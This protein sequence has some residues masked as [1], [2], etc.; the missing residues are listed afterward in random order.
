MIALVVMA[1]AIG[2]GS[3]DESSCEQVICPAGERCDDGECVSTDNGGCEPSCGDGEI[4]RDDRCLS[5]GGGCDH[6][7]QSCDGSEHLQW[8]EDFICLD[9][10]TGMGS[11]AVCSQDCRTQ[12][13]PEGSE[14]FLVAPGVGTQCA[15][16][17]ECGDQEICEQG[18][19][20]VASCRPSDCS[21][22]DG[23]YADCGPGER[24]DRIG[25]TADYCIPEGARQVGESC[26]DGLQALQTDSFAQ[27]CVAEA[28]C[29]GGMCERFC[30]DGTCPGEQEC[31]SR[32]A[33]EVEVEVCTS[34]CTP[35]EDGEGC[36]GQETCVPTSDG[37]GV[38]QPAGSIE[39]FESCDPDGEGCEM[40][41]ICAVQESGEPLG[42]CLP[43]CDLSVAELDEEGRLDSDGQAAR[44]ETCPQPQRE[45]GLWVVWHLA[46]AVQPLDV[47][48]GEQSEPLVQVDGG[49]LAEFESGELYEIRE[50]GRVEWR[51]LPQGAPATDVPI[52]EG[53]FDLGAGGSKMLVLTPEAG[54]DSRLE[55]NVVDVQAVDSMQWLQ[56]ISDL[57]DV[58]VWAIGEDGGSRL[59]FEEFS[60]GSIQSRDIDEGIYDL[61]LVASGSGEDADALLEFDGV[62]IAGDNA[63]AAFSGT[64]DD[65]DIHGISPPVLASADLP[66]VEA[67]LAFPLTCRA[68]NDGSVGGCME[69]CTGIDD[70]AGGRCRGEAMGCGPR[71][72]DHRSDWETVCQPVGSL[73]QGDSCF[74]QD[75]GAC[76]EGLYCQE[77][78]SGGQGNQQGECTP[79]CFVDSDAGCG[80]GQSCRSL[81]GLSQYEIGECRYECEPDTDY[82]D[83]DC[84]LRLKKCLPEG[85]LVPA[86][87]GVDGGYDV[88]VQQTYCWPSGPASIGDTCVPGN[89]APGGECIYARSVQTGFVESLLSPYVGSGAAGLQCRA[90]CEP[91]TDQYLSHQCGSDETCLFNYPWNANVGHCAEI[92]EEPGVGEPCEQ[93]GMACGED[94]ICLNE[95]GD[96]E[97]V[98]FCQFIGL[99]TDGY[100][101]STCPMGYSCYPFA[102]DI[103]ICD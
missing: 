7:G 81:D 3:G 65:G 18:Q 87:D 77:F 40:G 11:Q 67:E 84:P 94:S 16:D 36:A 101:R 20:M 102:N 98:Q 60:A 25:I 37:G 41:T 33:G 103:G 47:Y 5:E 83:D 99:G 55:S 48:V 38:C 39:A 9:W 45:E 71:F 49:A 73:E 28:V 46:P 15:I 70:I 57:E 4:C 8:D 61:R 17:L 95:D 58:D 54:R 56:G 13:C 86:G 62:E 31:V 97:C 21:V 43:V 88:E 1:L 92:V 51:A 52:I 23:L 74:P 82:R 19:C 89:C 75:S 2:C 42:R 50:A 32:A 29:V 64:M 72:L 27:G 96:S 35:G 66:D 53:Q 10:E 69:V 30:D 63:L 85:R 78:G 14:C 44:D 59:W 90:V 79:L 26:I 22:A 6:H 68:I 80:D 91:F 93:P 34:T 100:E 24:C 12:P 76:G